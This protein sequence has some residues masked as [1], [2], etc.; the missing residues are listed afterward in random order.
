MVEVAPLLRQADK[1]MF[2]FP[3]EDA[4]KSSY[5]G[6]PVSEV[7]ATCNFFGKQ[8]IKKVDINFFVVE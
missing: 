4:T 7:I 2:L 3:P 6:F 1:V 8:S 5:K